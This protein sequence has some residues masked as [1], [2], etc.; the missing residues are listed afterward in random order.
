VGRGWLRRVGGVDLGACGAGSGCKRRWVGGSRKGSSALLC[1][2]WLAW[3]G[4]GRLMTMACHLFRT[5]KGRHS[6]CVR[7]PDPRRITGARF[8]RTRRRRGPRLRGRLGARGREHGAP[9]PWSRRRLAMA[10]GRRRAGA[11][12]MTEVR[13]AGRVLMTVQRSFWAMHGPM[14]ASTRAEMTAWLDRRPENRRNCP[15]SARNGLP[16]GESR[17]HAFHPVDIGL[18]ETCRQMTP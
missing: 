6:A 17:F 8:Q 13:P 14:R 7:G 9:A 11:P 4:I 2:H 1:R 10:G 16:Y 5:N 3:A 15:R 12:A 18:N